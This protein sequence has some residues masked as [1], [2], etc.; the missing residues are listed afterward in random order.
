[1]PLFRRDDNRGDLGATANW[2]GPW[3]P[4][5]KRRSDEQNGRMPSWSAIRH[6]KTFTQTFY[7]VCTTTTSHGTT[8]RCGVDFSIS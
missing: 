5:S 8:V 7:L 1:M 4:C 6:G 3:T 2:E